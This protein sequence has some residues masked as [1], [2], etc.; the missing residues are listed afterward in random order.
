MKSNPA[1]LCTGKQPFTSFTLAN[2]AA[3]R[4]NRNKDASREAYHC[5]H[6]HAWHVGTQRAPHAVR[7]KLRMQLKRRHDSELLAATGT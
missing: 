3:R 2:E 1:A 6:C 4:A 5:Q 7:N